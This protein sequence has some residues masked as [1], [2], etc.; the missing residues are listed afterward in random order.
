MQETMQDAVN[1][2]VDPIAAG[3]AFDSH[4]VIAQLIKYHSDAY[5]H[6]A[7]SNETT[8]QMH[9]RIAQLIGDLP[10]VRKFPQEPPRL[11]WSEHIHG[12]PGPCALWEKI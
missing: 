1:Q 2:I 11:S 9:G 12:N 8:A 10:T 3:Y 6:F 4:F 7:G 5:I